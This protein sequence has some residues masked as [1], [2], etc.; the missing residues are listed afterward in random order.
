VRLLAERI[1]QRLGRTVVAPVVAYVPEGS[2]EPPTQ[3][4]RYAGTITVPEPAFESMLESAVRSLRRHGLRDVVL[5]GD[6]GGYHRSLERVA[7]RFAAGGVAGKVIA[8][9]EYYRAS[10]GEHARLLT[11]RG[12]P[13]AEIGQHAGLAD[14]SLTLALEPSQVRSELLNSVR[15]GGVI[16]DPRRASAELGRL[17]VERIVEQSVQAIRARLGRGG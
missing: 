7:A 8:L 5:I 6:H 11:E 10:T 17:G 1:A 3:H 13:T 12:F 9:P 14:T 2:I 15:G 4:M 16:G